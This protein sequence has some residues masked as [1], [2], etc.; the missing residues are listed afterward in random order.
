MRWHTL[1]HAW[2]WEEAS[3]ERVGQER[4]VHNLCRG[5]VLREHIGLRR[6]NSVWLSLGLGGAEPRSITVCVFAKNII[7]EAAHETD[8]T[9]DCGQQEGAFRHRASMKGLTLLRSSSF[10]DPASDAVSDM[11]AVV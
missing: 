7:N 10:S 3:N 6:R 8:V 11:V 4:T 5:L 1:Q 2:G 9:E